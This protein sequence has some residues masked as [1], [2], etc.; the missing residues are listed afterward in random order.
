MPG[1]YPPAGGF[2]HWDTEAFIAFFREQG[3]RDPEQVGLLPTTE[4]E[5]IVIV[6]PACMVGSPPSTSAGF[7]AAV[8]ALNAHPPLA[9]AI[10]NRKAAQRR[11]PRT[12]S[13]CDRPG[14]S[15]A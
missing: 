9:P 3:W 6:A 1:R 14:G 7:S 8:Q 12:Q 13:V 2:N 11:A 10:E 5:P 15:A 4:E